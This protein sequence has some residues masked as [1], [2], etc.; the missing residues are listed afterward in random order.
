[1]VI[2]T[3][4]KGLLRYL[5]IIHIITFDGLRLGYGV[6]DILLNKNDYRYKSL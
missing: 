3:T 4:Q 2:V 5:F 1:M 6:R